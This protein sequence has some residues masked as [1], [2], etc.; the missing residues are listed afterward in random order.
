MQGK[1]SPWGT[2]QDAKELIPGVWTIHTAGHGGVKL[3]RKLNARV[4][5]FIR[6]PGG[7]YE[8]DCEWSLAVVSLAA[9]FEAGLVDQ[10]RKTAKSWYPDEYTRLTGEN[11]TAD[12]SH[13]VAGREFVERNRD[14]WVAIAAWGA[15]HE[16]VPS[17]KVGV[18]ATVGGVRPSHGNMVPTAYFL[19]TQERYDERG[20]NAYV[21]RDTDE[22][23]QGP[24]N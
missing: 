19:T 13:I 1:S 14:K 9:L 11:V 8:E 4:P 15:W 7:W 22:P 6:R 24:V 16:A 20:S 2:I 3:D 21:V 5:E 23:W 17:G 10:A 18:F 12:E